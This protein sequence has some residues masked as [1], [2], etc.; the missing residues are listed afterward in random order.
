MDN[1]GVP[2]LDVSAIGDNQGNMNGG[3]VY[4]L[5]LRRNPPNGLPTIKRARKITTGVQGFKPSLLAN[6]MFGAAVVELPDLD[7]DNVTEMAIGSY[8]EQASPVYFVY[9]NSL[10]P[11]IVQAPKI[12]AVTPTTL[13]TAGGE[14]VNLQISVDV[15]AFNMSMPLEIIVIIGDEQCNVVDP[16]L[17]PFTGVQ[18]PGQ[19]ISLDQKPFTVICTSP[20]G[21]GGKLAVGAT[22]RQGIQEV[23]LTYLQTVSYQSPTVTSVKPNKTLAR[24]G[25]DV[26]VTGTSFGTK[27]YAPM[28]IVNGIPCDSTEWVSDTEVI[29]K[30][31]PPGLGDAVVQVAVVGQMSPLETTANTFKYDTPVITGWNISDPMTVFLPIYDDYRLPLTYSPYTGGDEILQVRPG[32]H[33][34]LLYPAEQHG[35]I[36]AVLF[37]M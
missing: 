18:F 2:E 37:L 15:V 6:Q 29:C 20:P 16:P 33:K 19:I 32:C 21:V 9:K 24:G 30:G 5:F 4:V 13:S 11:V 1:D 22:I 17:R 10:A 27:D 14:T 28:V 36:S 31:A 23:D 8:M 3:A 35:S 25:F 7:G 34:A 26:T 12:F